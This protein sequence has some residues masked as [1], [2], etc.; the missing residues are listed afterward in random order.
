MLNARGVH[1]DPTSQMFDLRHNVEVPINIPNRTRRLGVT[2]IVLEELIT[3]V[4]SGI[5]ISNDFQ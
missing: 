2:S 5:I 4:Q 3:F 1:L